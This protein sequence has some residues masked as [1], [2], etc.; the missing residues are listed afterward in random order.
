MATQVNYVGDGTTVTYAI[1]FDYA[2]AGTDLKVEVNGEAVEF[3]LDSASTLR[4]QTAPAAGAA[5]KIYRQTPFDTRRVVFAD[6]AVLSAQDLNSADEQLFRKVEEVSDA[7]ADTAAH[8]LRTSPGTPTPLVDLGSNPE[9]KVLG[10]VGGAIKPVANSAAEFANAASEAKAEIDLRAQQVAASASAV[11]AQASAVAVNT[12]IVTAATETVAQAT[13]DTAAALAIAMDFIVGERRFKAALLAD[14][15]AQ[16]IAAT[17]DGQTFAATSDNVT[18]VGVFKKVAGVAEE[19]WKAPKLLLPGAIVPTTITHNR[20]LAVTDAL[21]GAAIN[22]VMVN[23]AAPAGMLASLTVPSN[24]V[25]PLPLN[26]T[27]EFLY[28]GGAETRF[29]ADS[30]GEATVVSLVAGNVVMSEVGSICRLRKTGINTWLLYPV[31]GNLGQQSASAY[32]VKVFLDV[33]ALD[34]MKQERTGAAA[35]TPVTVGSPVGTFRNLGS[36]GGYATATADARRPILRQNATGRYYLETDGTD[37]FLALEGV[38]LD[39]AKLHLFLAFQPLAYGYARGIISASPVDTSGDLHNNAF[40][41]SHNALNPIPSDFT[42]QMGAPGAT[43]MAVGV[44]GVNPKRPHVW[45]FK[46]TANASPAEMRIDNMLITHAGTPASLPALGNVTAMVAA[47]V[48]VILGANPGNLGQGGAIQFS[49]TA[50]YGLLLD[51][52]V[53]TDSQRAGVRG[54]LESRTYVAPPVF[55]LIPDLTALEAARTTLRTEVFGGALPIDLA[56]KAIDASPPVTG[57]ANLSKVEKLTIPGEADVK[58]KPRLWT[59]NGARTDVVAL[60]WAG[61]DA[62]AAN[63]GIR[64]FALQPLLTAGVTVV[65]MVL[66]DGAND[67]TSGG[68]SQHGANQT[69]YAKWARQAVV[70]INTLL[71]MYPGAK[72]L[73]TGISGGGW[74]TTLCA[75]LDPRITTSVQFV[76]SI[77]EFIYVNVDYEQWLTQITANY[78]DLYL[79]ASANGRRHRQVLHENDDAGFTRA[80]YNSRPPYAPGLSARAAALGGYYDLTWFNYSAHALNTDSRAL[81]LSELPAAP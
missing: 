36:L 46:K 54:F 24:S 28:M 74:A 32:T 52:T 44:S 27:F 21:D 6:S 15:V 26:T 53:M 3:T 9:G 22:T 13:I 42:F 62:G 68:P 70:A 77:P 16:G 14:A 56:T 10:I 40:S 72:V 60:I 34:T 33:A 50:Y 23:I 12:G 63:N 30:A 80:A 65:T 75:A 49:R 17:T 7:V 66:P 58:V 39:F 79:L 59:P 25:D 20:P 69:P 71:A 61:H 29:V 48:R 2:D 35:T 57:L 47:T 45:E 78:L 41:I 19:L 43:R 38:P 5:L 67:Y 73:M 1:P 4:L 11:A 55:P 31:R 18:Y 64:D 8:A 51:D 37:D 76:G 81:L